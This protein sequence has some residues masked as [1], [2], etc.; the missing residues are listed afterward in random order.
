M[1]RIALAWEHFTAIVRTMS[2]WKRNCISLLAAAVCGLSVNAATE[3]EAEA[4]TS[5]YERAVKLWISEMKLASSPAAMEMIKKKR[6]DAAEY[7]K[8]LKRLLNRDLDKG[9]TLKYATWL[10][11]NDPNLTAGSQRALLNAVERH[12]MKS[13]QLGSFAIAM[14][15]LNERGGAQVKGKEA[16][17][18][19][20]IKMLEKI[21]T[22][23][24]DKKVQGQAALAL[25]LMYGVMGEDAVAMRKRI[26]NL[27][28]AILKS[29]DVKV[30]SRTVADIAK[31]QLYIIRNLTKGKKAPNIVGADSASRAVQLRDFGGKVVM[32]VFWSSFDAELDR[33]SKGLEMLRKINTAKLG[34]PF[35]ILGVNRDSLKNLRALEADR[36]VT[37]RNISDPQQKIAKAYHIPYWPY[38]MVLDQKGMI[39]YSGALGA[40]ADAVATDL[41]ANKPAAGKQ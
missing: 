16:V 24:P 8:K 5:G 29:A 37:W 17:R 11:E 15:N 21:K 22:V 12:H 39:R 10:L 4:I 1:S 30:G 34:K 14:T 31:E 27:R 13:T 32:L 35:V 38:C 2:I 3:T 18:S 9:W 6:P 41:L 26:S 40:F 36:I 25:S 28:E 23:N 33:V 20:G 19:R 7:A